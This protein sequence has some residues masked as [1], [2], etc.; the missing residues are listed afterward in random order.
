MSGGLLAELIASKT[1]LFYP[2]FHV[3]PIQGTIFM[4]RPTELHDPIAHRPNN[5][6]INCEYWAGKGH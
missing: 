1:V 5:C 3:Q 6:F 2:I 4:H